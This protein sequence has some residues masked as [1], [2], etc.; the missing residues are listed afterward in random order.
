MK[1]ITLEEY[2]NLYAIKEKVENA[3]KNKYDGMSHKEWLKIIKEENKNDIDYMLEVYDFI[4]TNV[5]VKWDIDAECERTF[6]PKES[7]NYKRRTLPISF[8]NKSMTWLLMERAYTND[9]SIK[10]HGSKIR[11]QK[12][13]VI[14]LEE[15]V[16]NLEKRDAEKEQQIIK[17]TD[18]INELKDMFKVSIEDI[19][20]K[21]LYKDCIK[22]TKEVKELQKTIQEQADKLNYDPYND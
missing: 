19:P 13:K 15:K 2:N 18:E 6:N 7:A 11:S 10:R 17:M 21:E 1:T 8:K 16:E 3:E 14:T 9:M 5:E 12:E 22:L 20:N 4:Y